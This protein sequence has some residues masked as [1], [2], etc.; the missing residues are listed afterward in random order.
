MSVLFI[1]DDIYFLII[2]NDHKILYIE[3]VS[4]SVDAKNVYFF[5][6]LSISAFIL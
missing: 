3:S 6:T 4:L 1:A 5:Y 2:K